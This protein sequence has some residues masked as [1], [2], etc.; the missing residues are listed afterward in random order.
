MELEMTQTAPLIEIRDLRVAFKSPQ[1]EL[2]AVRG[3]NL[4]DILE[5]LCKSFKLFST[6]VIADH[7]GSAWCH[8]A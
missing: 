1:G 8:L 6:V 4:V 2:E 7:T 3:V 5:K